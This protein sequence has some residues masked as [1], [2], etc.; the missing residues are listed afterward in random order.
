MLKLEKDHQLGSIVL[1]D[2]FDEFET[3][4][5]KLAP[6]CDD[7]SMERVVLGKSKKLSESGSARIEAR[8]DIGEVHRSCLVSLPHLIVRTLRCPSKSPSVFCLCPE[9]RA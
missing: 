6:V 4:A 3:E 7:E 2:S 9:P 5:S 8:A 1:K